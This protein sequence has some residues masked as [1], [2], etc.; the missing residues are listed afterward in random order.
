VTITSHRNQRPWSS[1]ESSSAEVPEPATFSEGCYLCPGNTRVSGVQ[2]PNY[3]SVYVFD[4]DHPSFSANAP[5]DLPA[6][7]GIYRNA[8][9]SGTTRVMCY[10]PNHS[11]SLAELNEEGFY[12]VFDTWA[13][14]TKELLTRSDVEQVL[15]FENKGDVIGVSNPHPHC[16]IYAASFEF[17]NLELE[18]VAMETHQAET[19]RELMA[20]IMASEMDA[21]TRVIA[22]TDD[23]LSFLPYFSR[24]PFEAFVCPKQSSNYLYELSNEALRGMARVTRDLLVRFDNLWR[25]PFPYMLVLHQAPRNYQGRYHTH[26]QIHPLM[27]QPSLQ[28]FLAGVESGGGHFLNDVDPDGAA[29]QLRELSDIHYLSEQ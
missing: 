10:S 8:P 20:D 14:Q 6:P 16:Q 22:N 19:N 4:N 27:R 17:K 28:K 23:S 24:F 18:R 26:I 11:L 29:K 13:A 21:G 1:G 2:N 9:A 7:T 15:I 3:R 12:E 25:K 5:T